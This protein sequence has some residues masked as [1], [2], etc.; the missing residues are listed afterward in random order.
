ML[1]RDLRQVEIQ[2][3]LEEMLPETCTLEEW[4]AQVQE[5]SILSSAREAQA[6]A[7][8]AFR[9]KLADIVNIGWQNARTKFAV[10]AQSLKGHANARESTAFRQGMVAMDQSS[11]ENRGP[12]RASDFIAVV[13]KV[14][15][16][17][18]TGVPYDALHDVLGF[19]SRNDTGIK[20]AP[21]GMRRRVVTSGSTSS[22]RVPFT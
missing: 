17:I 8:D 20:G 13:Q 5:V 11:D 19:E 14:N 7:Q 4:M 21:H 18:A 3:T 1:S 9:Q 12:S 6:S 10:S 15:K 16:A 22:I 2:P